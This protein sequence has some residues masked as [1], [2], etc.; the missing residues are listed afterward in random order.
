MVDVEMAQ[1]D[2][3]DVGVQGRI[4]RAD[5]A[6]QEQQAVDEDRIGQDPKPARAR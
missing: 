2:E 6:G 3:V 1:Q 4:D 5:D